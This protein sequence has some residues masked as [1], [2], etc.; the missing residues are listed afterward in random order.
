[1]F[2]AK[3]SK[4]AVFCLIKNLQNLQKWCK[5]EII[6]TIKLLKKAIYMNFDFVKVGTISP[7]IKVADVE[8][9]TKSIKKAL[10]TPLIW[11]FKFLLFHNYR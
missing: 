11:V 10:M 4:N 9:N 3:N 7:E 1:M 8:F 5:I 2:F 6:K